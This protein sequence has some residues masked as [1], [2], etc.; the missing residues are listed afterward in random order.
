V[1]R[2]LYSTIISKG[3]AIRMEGYSHVS[4]HSAVIASNGAT[5]RSGNTGVYVAS[6]NLFNHSVLALHTGSRIDAATNGIFVTNSHISDN[7]VVMVHTNCTLAAAA[8]NAINL[9]S[10][11][12][13][14]SAVY[15]VGSTLTSGKEDVFRDILLVGGSRMFL[16]NSIVPLARLGAL[17]PVTARCNVDEATRAPFPS[18]AY[19]V[20]ST[21]L[22]GSCTACMKDVD[23]YSAHTTSVAA[24]VTTG[25]CVCTCI[26]A[27]VDPVCVALA[28]F[29]CAAQE[30]I[31]NPIR[32]WTAT[33]AQSL[34]VTEES[35][36][37]AAVSA[38]ISRMAANEH[39]DDCGGRTPHANG[40][41]CA[42]VNRCAGAIGTAAGGPNR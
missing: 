21:V 18:D 40:D 36:E 25:G 7:S 3:D 38:S 17:P 42:D 6:S 4:D 22:A 30:F 27:S 12:K 24:N 41:A 19:S 34:T 26:N 15:A 11:L 9:F 29:P 39:S 28:S 23:C 1:L 37:S 14:N 33:R 35:S 13:S 16:L 8:G 32:P 5:L 2:A 20:G 31:Q 10:A